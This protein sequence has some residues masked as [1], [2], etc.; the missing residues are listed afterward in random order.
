M[1]KIEKAYID[2]VMMRYTVD[3]GRANDTKNL[4][5]YTVAMAAMKS[6]LK[7]SNV[8]TKRATLDNVYVSSQINYNRAYNAANAAYEKA[9]NFLVATERALKA[10]N[11]SLEVR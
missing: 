5:E 10:A 11:K 6:S 1:K 3:Y 2:T 4:Q 7:A 8:F 9:P